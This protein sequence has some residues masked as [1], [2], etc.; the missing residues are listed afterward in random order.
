MKFFFSF[1][2]IKMTVDMYISRAKWAQGRF[3]SQSLARALAYF[4][5]PRDSKPVGKAAMDSLSQKKNTNINIHRSRQVATMWKYIRISGRHTV[6][7]R[8]V[9]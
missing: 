3:P 2:Y 5:V 8:K 9:K 1:I 6:R 7:K 4:P